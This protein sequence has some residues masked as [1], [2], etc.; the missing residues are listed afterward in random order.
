[1]LRSALLL[2]LDLAMTLRNPQAGNDAQKAR[3]RFL[4]GSCYLSPAL[5]TIF[6]VWLS[7]WPPVTAPACHLAW[8]LPLFGTLSFTCLLVEVHGSSGLG[9]SGA[10]GRWGQGAGNPGAGRGEAQGKC[11]EGWGGLADGRV[12]L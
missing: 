11:D 9:M 8:L 4:N 2:A 3:D 7:A 12:W 10:E 1:M 5:A 6:R